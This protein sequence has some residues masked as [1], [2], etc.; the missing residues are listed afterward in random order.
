MDKE[1]VFLFTAVIIGLIPAIIAKIK[2]RS[3]CGWWIYGASLFVV[4]LPHALIM[5]PTEQQQ[6]THGMKRCPYCAELIKK[7]AVVCRD[8]GK[9]QPI[10]N[11]ENHSEPVAAGLK[12]ASKGKFTIK[13]TGPDDP[14][15]VY[16]ITKELCKD[17]G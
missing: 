10:E 11:P 8:C 15:K 2:G 7:Q 5:K 12:D 16:L 13:I 4:A 14:Q 9:D 1:A 3:F 17:L 6:L